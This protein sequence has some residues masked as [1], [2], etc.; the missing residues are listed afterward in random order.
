VEKGISLESLG[1][2]KTM[3]AKL[4]DAIKQRIKPKE[5]T[6]NGVIDF[7]S[8]A[9]NGVEIVKEGLI[10]SNKVEGSDIKYLGG[11]RYKLSVNA[12]EYKMADAKIKEVT[13]LISD[14]AKKHSCEFS[15]AKSGK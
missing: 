8:Y 6:I 4:E 12:K 10:L 7:C 15:F 13:D 2:E 14:Y 1:I 11:G 5:V 3:A 9:G